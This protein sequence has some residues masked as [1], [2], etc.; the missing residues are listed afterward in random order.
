MQIWGLLLTRLGL[1]I[2][3]CH[4]WCFS[5]YDIIE[6]FDSENSLPDSGHY[7]GMGI[8]YKPSTLSMINFRV[9]SSWNAWNFNALPIVRA[10]MQV[11]LSI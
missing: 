5:Q 4:S 11:N 2:L 1:V 7:L 6:N 3:V 8:G 9:S 10:A